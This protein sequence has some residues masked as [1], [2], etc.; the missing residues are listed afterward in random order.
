MIRFIFWII[1]TFVE[2]MAVGSAYWF[3]AKLLGHTLDYWNVMRFWFVAVFVWEI[4]A[5]ISKGLKEE[6][7]GN[8]SSS[9]NCGGTNFPLN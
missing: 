9:R 1:G 6:W 2:A 3:I 4:I 5:T 8:S 7:G